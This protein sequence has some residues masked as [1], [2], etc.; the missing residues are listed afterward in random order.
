MLYGKYGQFYDLIY[1]SIDY[2][3]EIEEIITLL[4]SKRTGIKSILDIGCGTGSYVVGLAKKGYTVDGIDSSSDMIESAQTKINASK[5]EA[6]VCLKDMNELLF[7]KKYDAVICLFGVIDYLF[8]NSDIQKLFAGI[9]KSL[10]D[11]GLLILDFLAKDF[12][13]NNKPKAVILE[14]QQGELRSFRATFP[15]IG[16]N[17]E[18]LTLNFKCTIYRAREILDYF[19]ESHPLRIFDFEELLELLEENNLSMETKAKKGFYTRLLVQKK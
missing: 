1:S 12:F 18:R 10:S 4:N 5:I 6:N 7:D 11:G 8:E 14:G 9:H 16:M 2:N 3:G 19:E 17:G 13:K 15:E